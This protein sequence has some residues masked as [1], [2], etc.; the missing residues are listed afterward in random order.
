M[1][2]FLASICLISSL[3]SFFS[4]LNEGGKTENEN[5]L[6]QRM[7]PGLL[8]GLLNLLKRGNKLTNKRDINYLASGRDSARRKTMC[9]TWLRF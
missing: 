2:V 4:L 1:V 6:F 3:F 7:S 8:F 5:I 9:L